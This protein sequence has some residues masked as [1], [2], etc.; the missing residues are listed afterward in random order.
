ME[1]SLVSLDLKVWLK[2]ARG[3]LDLKLFRED[4]PK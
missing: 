2:K 4:G 1:N 3:K